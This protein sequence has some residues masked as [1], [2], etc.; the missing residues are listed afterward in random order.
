LSRIGI[1]DLRVQ[2][3]SHDFADT[4]P[5]GSYREIREYA[6][7]QAVGDD[8]A[9]R[10]AFAAARHAAAAHGVQL[11]LPRTTGRTAATGAASPGCTWPWDGAYITSAG[12][13]QPCCMVMGDDRVALGRLAERSFP[14]IWA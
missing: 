10:D 7:D 14:E 11:R 6:R 1:T 3:L 13:V 12:V 4:D 2:N 9:T 8:A 5:D